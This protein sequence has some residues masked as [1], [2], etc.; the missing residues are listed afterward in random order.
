MD[1]GRSSQPGSKKHRM[2]LERKSERELVVTRIVDAPPRIVF[3]AWTKAE[4]FKQWWVPKSFGLTLLSCEMDV[5]VGGGYRLTFSHQGSE[6]MA[7]YG[8]YL[9]VTPHSRLVWT[10]EEGGEEGAVTSVTFE[11][12]AG[13]TLVVLR[14]LYPSKEALD[15]AL[16]TSGTG[17]LPEAFAQLDELLVSLGG[18]ARP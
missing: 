18:G 6:P 11:E 16:A 2:S 4:L 3:E 12:K 9:E 1:A 7:F 15:A 8:K 13:K 10:N 5:R 14:D 17:A